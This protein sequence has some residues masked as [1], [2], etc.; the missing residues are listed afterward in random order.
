MDKKYI[1]NYDYLVGLKKA[2]KQKE[3]AKDFH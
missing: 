1:S 2:F 3:L